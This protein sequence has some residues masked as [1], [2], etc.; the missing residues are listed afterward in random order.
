MKSIWSAALGLLGVVVGCSAPEAGSKEL[1]SGAAS[2]SARPAAGLSDFEASAL[3]QEASAP[4]IARPTG[5]FPCGPHTCRRYPNAAEAFRAVIDQ[6]H[7]LV[8]AL[9]ET[10]AQKGTEGVAST[11]S[12]FTEDLLPTLDGKASSIVLELWVAD[13]KC[14]K[15]KEEKVAE[16]QK[17]VTKNQAEGNANEFT[18]LGDKAKSLGIVPFILRPTCEEYDKVLAAGDDAIIE[19]LT[20]ITRN[21]RSKAT[22]LFDETQKTKPGRM[23]VTYGGAMHNDRAPSAARAAWSFGPDLEKL[24]PGRMV[25]LD[26]VVPEFIKDT[27]SW[28]TMPWFGAYDRETM[29]DTAVLVTV[30]PR[31][32]AIIFPRTP[33][34]A[35]K[36]PVQD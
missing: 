5:P 25:D 30:A 6:D 7:P 35:A 4:A 2:G 13:G 10:H 1:A 3:P 19:M 26:L 18:K 12:R 15:K 34:S 28:R 11:T 32:Y 29:G 16:K 33:V 20:M 27:E 31:S 8:L 17:P 24:A 9:G 36:P 23:V 22:L 14:G 21:M